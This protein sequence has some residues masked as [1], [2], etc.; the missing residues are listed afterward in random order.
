MRKLLTPFLSVPALLSLLLLAFSA[1]VSQAQQEASAPDLSKYLEA[2]PPLPLHTP[3]MGRA[4][5]VERPEGITPPTSQFF[6]R[7]S[8]VV[9]VM[10]ASRRFSKLD[11]KPDAPYTWPDRPLVVW[12]RVDGGD[13]PYTFEM[14]FGDGSPPVSG[15]VDGSAGR[16]VNYIAE[17]HVYSTAGPKLARLTVTDASNQVAWR[18]IPIYVEP[19]TGNERDHDL[20]LH[21]NAAI[22]D[23]LRWLYLQQGSNGAWSFSWYGYA[24]YYPTTA[25][26]VSAF[27]MAGYYPN[28]D[29]ES[30]IYAEFIR[31]GLE[32]LFTGL[33]QNAIGMQSHG[34][35]DSNG[36]GYGLRNSSLPFGFLHGLIMYAIALSRD[37]GAIAQSGGAGVVGRSYHEL[38]TDLMDQLAWSQGDGGWSEGGWRYYVNSADSGSDNSIVQWATVALDA[39]ERPENTFQVQAPAWVKSELQKWL[40]YSR[41]GSGSYGYAGS[42]DLNSLG[43]TGSGIFSEYYCGLNINMADPANDPR[44]L[45][46]RSVLNSRWCVSDAFPSQFAGNYY[47]MYAIKKALDDLDI[48]Y[49]VPPAT[50]DWYA[51]YLHFLLKGYTTPC[52]SDAYHQ[53]VELTNPA[54]VNLEGHGYWPPDAIWVNATVPATALA[55][56]ILTP[57]ISCDLYA[58]AAAD[59]SPV[60]PGVSV[61][62]DGGN[63]HSNCP[64]QQIVAWLWDFDDRDGADIGLPDATGQTAAKSDGYAL[65]L[66]DPADTVRATLW[67]IN[68]VVP[69]DTVE[70]K[71]EVVVTRINHAP[72]ACL[73]GPF[74]AC[75]GYPLLLNACCSADPD[76]GAPCGPD[77]LV[78]YEWDLGGEGTIDF[79]ST[80]CTPDNVFVFNEET[81][82]DVV[83]WVTDTRGLRSTQAAAELRWSLLSDLHVAT[84]D[85][86]FNPP[87][88]QCGDSVEVC[89]GIHVSVPVGVAPIAETKVRIYHD[90]YLP[91]D[92]QLNLIC[93]QTLTNLVDGQVVPVCC[94]WVV[95]TPSEIIV[96]ADADQ[97][98]Q[99]CVE[100]DNIASKQVDCIDG[101]SCC[102]AD[103]HC[104]IREH[105]DCLAAGGLPQD[106]NTTCAPNPCPPPADRCLL[107]GP[108]P[109]WVDGCVAGNDLMYSTAVAGIDIDFDPNC[110]K[111]LNLVLAGPVAV[112]RSGPLDDSIH[113]PGTR[114]TDAHLDVIDTEIVTMQL[115]GGG[116]T[117]KA[118]AGLGSQPLAPTLGA[119]AEQVGNPVTADSFFDVFFEVSGGAIPQ[120]LY[121]QV[122]LRLESDITCIPPGNMYSHVGGCWEL[123]TSPIPGQGTHLA[124]LVSADHQPLPVEG[125]CCFGPNCVALISTDC[126][127]QEGDYKGDGV[128]CSPTPCDPS[129]VESPVARLGV[130][131]IDVA[132]NPAAGSISIRYQPARA[133]R[134]SLVI[135]D[136]SGRLVRDLYDGHATADPHMLEWDGRDDGGQRVPAGVYFCRLQTEGRKVISRPMVLVE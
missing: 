104:E 49:L 22:Q 108:G 12:G 92:P 84:E 127:A 39:A 121:N 105:A 74:T 112:H 27:E 35:P 24:P 70:T 99:E 48:A 102:F 76:D 85:I 11:R 119:I 55:L 6:T 94:D 82:L 97:Q 32:Y 91:Q 44:I 14:T 134:T 42:A 107:C 41:A 88:G 43:L 78:L 122:P 86:T 37:P 72:V 31:K 77:S 132:P 103:G 26:A 80:T 21:R 113:Y 95:P 61:S 98:V 53:V 111:D 57:G 101:V 17:A 123:Y 81:T 130:T 96:V 115:T 136:A 125:A 106:P 114:P 34:N 56:L 23:G 50:V 93:E 54:L 110:L 69:P 19:L 58:V 51:D 117:L 128:S 30:D 66:E 29:P 83:L 64:E 116:V 79:T 15:N 75:V 131:F 38:L 20:L 4:I 2:Y 118:G 59:P 100:T 52:L 71:V 63:S 18:D 124:N 7:T 9:R 13:A 120:P 60:C 3:D 8:P 68:D 90:Q 73:N 129:A 135:F 67:V 1:G 36:N 87:S 47:T 133:G 46:S 25:A 65:A 126:I 28:D 109:H 89:A 5:E 62:F 45:A 16:K 40:L 33:V 10:P